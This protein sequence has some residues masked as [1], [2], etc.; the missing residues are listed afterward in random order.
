MWNFN[1]KTGMPNL[2]DLESF[3]PIDA[4]GEFYQLDLYTGN[5]P[6]GLWIIYYGYVVTE[7]PYVGSLIY[8]QEGI[9]IS[10][11]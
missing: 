8:N 2:F 11:E 10:V 5:M 3:A 6:S 7:G 4:L 9:R 1:S